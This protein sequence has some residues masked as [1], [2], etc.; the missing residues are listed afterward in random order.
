MRK[1]KYR[2]CNNE[3]DFKINRNGTEKIYCSRK[4][5]S[6]E[7][8]YVKRDEKY[9]QDKMDFNNKILENIKLAKEL[10]KGTTNI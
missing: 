10:L 2:N 8:I 9:Y 7:N 3:F 1:C 6:C 4:C 5:K